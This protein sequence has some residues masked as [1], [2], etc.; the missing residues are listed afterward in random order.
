MISEP[1]L[2]FDGRDGS[3]GDGAIMEFASSTYR[4]APYRIGGSEQREERE[5]ASALLKGGS[6]EA[7]ALLNG[8]SEEPAPRALSDCSRRHR[9]LFI[10]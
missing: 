4:S 2:S 6:E 5:E 1:M 10:C 3:G 9:I 8:G 7:S